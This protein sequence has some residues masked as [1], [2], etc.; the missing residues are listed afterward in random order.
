MALPPSSKY[1]QRAADPVDETERESLT[2]RLNSAFADG[3]ITHDE[4]AGS[5]DVV[6]AA[7]T[8]GDLVPVIERLPAAATEVPA[9]VQQGG[10]PAG[11][12]SE[13]RNL[14]PIALGVGVVGVALVA[15]LL[16]LLVITFL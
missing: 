12:V 10:P 2:T 4:Y 9:I 15:V 6:Y 11:R 16:L 7:R 5:M 8:L 13:P 14:V 3:R 1:L